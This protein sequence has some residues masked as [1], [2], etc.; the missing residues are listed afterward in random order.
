MPVREE[1]VVSLT[2]T[3]LFAG[4]GGSSTGMVA[5]GVS[6]KIAA[7]HWDLAI[8]VHNANHPTTD[9]A[10]ADIH[11]ADPHYF[12]KTD[13]LWASPECTKWTVASGRAAADLEPALIEDPLADEAAQRSR[14]LMYD[15]PRF[16]EVHR[17]R[18][19]IVENVVDV[20][21]RAKYKN[22]FDLWLHEMSKL[23]YAHRV[24]SLNSMHAQ[25]G[26]LP[27]PQ[28]RDR[29]YVG[30]WRIGDKPVDFEPALR[31]SAWCGRCQRVVE[32]RQAW[33]PGRSVGKYRQ[34][35]IYVCGTCGRQVE[36]GWL[37]AYTAIDWTLPGQRIGDRGKPLADKTRARI[38]A[39]IARYWRPL[40]VEAGGHTYDAASP[41]HPQH[42]DPGAYY[43]AW[44]AD[45]PLRA[46]HGSLSKAL[47]VPVE[48][49]DGKTALPVD[50]PMRTMTT[51]AETA[52]AF[53]LERRFE[54]RTRSLDEPMATLTAN[55]TSK[56]LV[57]PFIA[58][59]RGGGSDARSVGDPL[60]TVTASGNHHGLVVPAGGT[61]NDEA[62]ST[63]DAHRAFTTRD[64]Y[65]LVAP[66]Y[67]A[68]DSAHPVTNP[69]G[70]LSTKDHHALIMRNFTPR[71][72]AAMMSTPA[73][74]VLRTLTT[75]GN[76][77][78]ITPGEVEAA[79][80]MVDD[81]QFRM[82][83]PHEV[84]AG[85]AFPSDYQWQGSKRNRVKLAGN[86]VT[87]PAARDL[88]AC[89]AEA[90]GAA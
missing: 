38:A 69:L 37:P 9:H 62:R 68:S 5:A 90:L 12:P 55:D 32:S 47:A 67:G 74:E 59:L 63:D 51:R 86:A 2:T 70:T 13:V 44:P 54:Y 76:Q 66:Y 79:R 43:R 56:A 6:V 82:L 21:T 39:G 83:E 46:L 19:I 42:G 15:V 85:M 27:A 18:A 10:I 87:P 8:A 48:G 34:Q 25:T 16:A 84:A 80:A 89:V 71:G 4:A 77:S 61:W 45:D 41:N 88:M 17:Y 57:Q 60:A 72:G 64:A 50:H 11:Q 35:Y 58:E 33:K 22:A 30:F 65:A 29:L 20:A 26:G 31:P 49:R 14:M 7:N 40:I 78:L 1:G 75:Q 28:S 53:M 73:D 23:G 24:I 36:P 52:L 3:D 81:C